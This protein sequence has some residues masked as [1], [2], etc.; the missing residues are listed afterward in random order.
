MQLLK[1]CTLSL[2][3]LPTLLLTE[4]NAAGKTNCK[5]FAAEQLQEIKQDYYGALSRDEAALAL[6]AA[7]RSCLALHG[8][9]TETLPTLTAQPPQNSEKKR[10]WW[11]N[12]SENDKA[13]PLLKKRQ[14]QGGK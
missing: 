1:A 6:E 7:E 8:N 5:Q 12:I 3:L 10:H 11:E 4:A 9:T 13:I 14:K 2:V